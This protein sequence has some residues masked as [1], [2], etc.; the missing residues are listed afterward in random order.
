MELGEGLGVPRLSWKYSWIEKIF[1]WGPAKWVQRSSRRIRWSLEG[2]LDKALFRIEDRR[3]AA[4]PGNRR[5]EA[6][7]SLMV[8]AMAA[9]PHDYEPPLPK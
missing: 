7:T 5:T 1:G 3:L 2:R 6:D 4:S 9:R 8:S